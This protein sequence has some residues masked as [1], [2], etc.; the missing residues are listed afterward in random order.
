MAVEAVWEHWGRPAI[1]WF[2]GS[3]LAPFGRGRVVRAIA[4]HLERLQ[5]L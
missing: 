5:I 2:S 1:H 4:E 3:H